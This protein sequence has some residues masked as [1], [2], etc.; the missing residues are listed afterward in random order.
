MEKVTVIGP[1]VLYYIILISD[2]SLAVYDLG[3][4]TNIPDW[5]WEAN[6]PSIAPSEP[7]LTS[8]PASPEG[9]L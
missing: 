8:M 4:Y 1:I 2:V 6:T 5:P 3:C 9:M 7:L